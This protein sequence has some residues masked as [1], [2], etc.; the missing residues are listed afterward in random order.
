MILIM[1]KKFFALLISC[2][3]LSGCGNADLLSNILT[4]AEIIEEGKLYFD[5][6]EEINKTKGDTVNSIGYLCSVIINEQ[7][8]LTD[9]NNQTL[10][11]N[12]IKAGD[13]INIYFVTP[14]NINDN[15][16]SFEAKK[17]VIVESNN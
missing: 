14:Q 5:C 12:E 8:V 16:K 1:I 10:T 2:I 6:S 7:T 9:N 15:N 13:L 3:L 11:L 4:E 17:I